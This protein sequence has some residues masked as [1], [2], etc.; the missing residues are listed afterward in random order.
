[1]PFI[2]DASVAV[3][4]LMPD[5]H[6]AVAQAAYARIARDSADIP[7]LWWYEL[8]NVLIVNERRRRFDP[9]KTALALR[10]LRALPIAIDAEED[11]DALMDI[12]RRHRLAVYDAT[13]LEL[14]LRR[15]LP[16]ATLDTALAAAARAEAVELV[17]DAESA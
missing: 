9:S 15:G 12:A 10:L 8:R 13:Y 17:G 16:L 11:E 7:V 14:A 3:C 4:W 6:H 5:E 1:M 2:V